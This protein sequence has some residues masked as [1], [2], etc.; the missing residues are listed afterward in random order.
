MKYKC[1]WCGEEF[2]VPELAPTDDFFLGNRMSRE[3]CPVCG[4]ED[5]W[6]TYERRRM[7][8]DDGDV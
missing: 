2:D 1:Y 4:S 5:F 8:Y 6:E 7:H 3:V